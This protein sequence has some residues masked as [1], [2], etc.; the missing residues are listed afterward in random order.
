MQ[1]N[2]NRHKKI[3]LKHFFV[4]AV[5]AVL[6]T[7]CAAQVKVIDKSA[8]KAPAWVNGIEKNFLIVSATA[9][10]VEEAKE[11][12]L[13]S[14]REQIV[15]AVAV[16]VQSSAAINV[17]ET[18][19]NGKVRQ[20][21]ETTGSTIHTKSGN[22]PFLNEIALSNAVDYYWEK[23]QDKKTK[24]V[25]VIYHVKYPFPEIQLQQLVFE[26]KEAD[27]KMTAQL[28][29]LCENIEAIKNLEDIGKNITALQ[30]LQKAF[31]D[32]RREQAGACIA[33]Y[34]SLYAYV[35]LEESAHPT[36]SLSYQLMLSGKPVA[37]IQKPRV[38]SNCA[39]NI[40][41]KLHD[42]GSADI[43]YQV[44][45]CYAGSDNYIEVT[46]NFGGKNVSQ[47]FFFTVKE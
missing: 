27:E 15:H 5:L 22:V 24:A 46:Y 34:R 28:A 41:V 12:I 8:K 21:L 36:G 30:Q 40:K 38:K 32:G 1:T 42:N 33:N 3:N 43:S 31:E 26:F 39:D 4:C 45:G 23:Q 9:N 18:A 47:K 37:A 44:D 16:N 2:G 13:N 7:A 17:Q 10:D 29:G 14:L 11:K 25:T 19:L 20:F 6:S 35:S